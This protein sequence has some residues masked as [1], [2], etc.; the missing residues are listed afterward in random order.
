MPNTGAHH[1]VDGGRD[2]HAGQRNNAINS[3]LRGGVKEAES[4][5]NVRR[6]CFRQ[7]CAKGKQH[8]AGMLPQ[9]YEQGETALRR[10]RPDTLEVGRLGSVHPDEQ[11][12]AD[13]RAAEQEG[14]APAPIKQRLLVEPRDKG[15]DARRE[16]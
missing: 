2:E 1:N 16:Q 3:E 9:Q 15:E 11:A 5:N 6:H 8:V 4:V 12:D 10:R 7:A 13:E 14:D